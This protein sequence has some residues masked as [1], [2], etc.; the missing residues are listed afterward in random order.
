MALTS[1]LPLTSGRGDSEGVKVTMGDDE[2]AKGN[3]IF[4]VGSSEGSEGSEAA[5]AIRAA[6]A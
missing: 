2:D 1:L 4:E 5:T 3:K 6:R